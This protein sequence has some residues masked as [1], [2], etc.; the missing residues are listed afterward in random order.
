[1]QNAD[2]KTEITPIAS[3]CIYINKL[4]YA[5]M[6]RYTPTMRILIFSYREYIV[7]QCAVTHLLSVFHC[8]HTSLGIGCLNP[9]SDLYVESACSAK[10]YGVL[11]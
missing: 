9:A 2:I 1:M 5:T 7:P 11:W 3:S 6:P 4:F 8:C 10:V